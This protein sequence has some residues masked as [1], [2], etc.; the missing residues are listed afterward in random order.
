M[1][2]EDDKI[3]RSLFVKKYIHPVD[4]EDTDYIDRKLVTSF[5][6]RCNS[7][8][9]AIECLQ[10]EV[11]QLRG[12]LAYILL[13]MDRETVLDCCELKEVSK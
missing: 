2:F 10:D 1:S 6:T 4:A 12:V 8:S 9:G 13:R 11:D 3:L 5:L 7:D